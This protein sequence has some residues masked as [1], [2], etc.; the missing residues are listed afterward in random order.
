MDTRTYETLPDGV[1]ATLDPEI[2]EAYRVAIKKVKQAGYPLTK[3]RIWDQYV[4]IAM[5]SGWRKLL[6]KHRTEDYLEVLEEEIK[7]K[8]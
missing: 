1:M 4:T 5:G 3:D 2:L 7:C 6:E 8:H